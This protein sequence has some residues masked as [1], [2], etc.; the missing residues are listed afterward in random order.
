MAVIRPAVFDGAFYPAGKKELDSLIEKFLDST[1]K[2]LPEFKAKEIKAIISP[3]AGYVYSGAVAAYGYQALKNFPPEDRDILILGPSHRVFIDRPYADPSDSWLTPLGEIRVNRSLIRRLGLKTDSEPHSQ[4][5]S[6]EVQLPFLQKILNN[7][8]IIP[9][10]LNEPSDELAEKITKIIDEII[11]IVS[12][13]LSHFLPYNEAV[14]TDKKTINAI[15]NL[16]ETEIL[17]VGENSACGLGGI[18]VLMRLARKLGL[19]PHLLKYLNSGDTAG[20]K[21]QVV[22]YASIIFVHPVTPGKP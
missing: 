4:E 21:D 16:D 1:P 18:L 15:L 22:G 8:S 17:K 6:L 14:A 10:V 5:H 12:S 20:G 7:F 13:D 9:I 2:N 19:K 3:H 11:I